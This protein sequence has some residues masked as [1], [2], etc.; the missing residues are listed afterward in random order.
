MRPPLRSARLVGGQPPSAPPRAWPCDGRGGSRSEARALVFPEAEQESLRASVAQPLGEGARRS[1]LRDHGAAA[2]LGRFPCDTLP[3]EEPPRPARRVRPHDGTL[4]DD[5]HHARHAQLRGHTDDGLH[6]VS[7]GEAL[8][9]GEEE[10]RLASARLPAQDQALG[11]P[12]AHLRELHGE[13]LPAAV[14][15]V[16]HI[17]RPE[18]EHTGQVTRL[19]R[20]EGDAR[21][22]H[23]LG[24]DRT[25]APGTQGLQTWHAKD[26]PSVRAWSRASPIRRSARATS[27]LPREHR[28]RPPA[29]TRH[30]AEPAPDGPGSGGSRAGDRRRPLRRLS[31]PPRPMWILQRAVE[32]ALSRAAGC[33]GSRRWRTRNAELHRGHGQDPV[34][35]PVSST[36]SAPGATRPS[37]Y[38]QPSDACC[39]SQGAQ[40]D[41]DG[42]PCRPPSSTVAM[43]RRLPTSRGEACCHALAPEAGR[44]GESRAL[45]GSP[46]QRAT[47]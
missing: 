5:G 29:A 6:L 10:R 3:A 39:P 43:I 22:A 30:G 46:G 28:H 32:A 40:V 25:L 14:H 21:T 13:L 11:R 23:R 44:L 24:E 17:A 47:G 37:E 34:P 8:D 31:G 27:F 42:C 18:A 33:V 4:R 45:P 7:L 19:L 38:R 15:G 2:L 20:V 36:P 9:E 41:D 12:R 16:D 26:Q 35:V 1:H